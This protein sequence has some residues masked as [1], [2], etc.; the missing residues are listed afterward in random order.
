MTHRRGENLELN[1]SLLHRETK[2]NCALVYSWLGYPKKKKKLKDVFELF[3]T[4]SI[5]MKQNYVGKIE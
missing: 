1:Q 4:N 2:N 3:F 5:Y